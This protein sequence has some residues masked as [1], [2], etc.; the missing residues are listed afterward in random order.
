MTY[1]HARMVSGIALAATAFFIAISCSPLASGFADAPSRGPSDVQLYWAEV[2]RVEAGENYYAAAEQELSQRGYPTHSLFNWRTPL[3]VW[4]IAQ[5]PTPESAKAA[6]A[7]LAIAAIALACHV[8]AREPDGSLGQGAFCGMLMVG[9]LLPCVLDGLYVMHE[10]W[11]GVLIAIS[12]LAYAIRRPT[13]GIVAG[14]AALFIR[15]LAAPY[16]VLCMVTALINRRWK[17]AAGW[18]A[19]G[20]GYLAWFAWH[21][22]HVLPRIHAGDAALGVGGALAHAA[23]WIQWGG[24]AFVISVV[25]MNGFLLLLPQWATALFLS[26]ALLGFACSTA[27][28]SKPVAQTVCLYLTLFAIVGQPL[29][30]YWGSLIA[31]LLCLGVAQAPKAIVD[32]WRAATAADHSAIATALTANSIRNASI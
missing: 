8:S 7:L 14:I 21:A 28:W 20:A 32:L 27:A 19:G 15:E 26:L 4:A 5:L 23:D 31:P 13:I 16:C 24:A 18:V 9:G 10:L 6:L 12:L 11:A 3:P 17:E 1:I 29:N 30:Q 22:A 2:A 25:Q